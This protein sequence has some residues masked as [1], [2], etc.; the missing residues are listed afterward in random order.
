MTGVGGF[1]FLEGLG[2]K[3]LFIASG[4]LGSELR[5]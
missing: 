1:W 2:P 5:V 4:D 3:G